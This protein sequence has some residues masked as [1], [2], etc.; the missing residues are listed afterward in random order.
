MVQL[1]LIIYI[2]YVYNSP[3]YKSFKNCDSCNTV[4][5]HGVCFLEFFLNVSLNSA[6]SVTRYYCHYSKRART[7][8]ILYKRPDAKT[9]PARHVWERGSSNWAKFILQ[10]FIRFPEFSE[11]NESSVPFRKNSIVYFN[12]RQLLSSYTQC[13]IIKIITAQIC[14]NLNRFSRLWKQLSNSY[15]CWNFVILIHNCSRL[16][17]KRN[18]QCCCSWHSG[19]Y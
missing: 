14:H 19:R 8:H 6:N 15:R 5:P 17:Q 4:T 10:R 18:M 1:W 11:F 7:C 2:D 9:A 16:S 3:L 12:F 13:A